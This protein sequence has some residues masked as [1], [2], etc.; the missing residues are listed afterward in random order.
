MHFL[1]EARA[2]A[3]LVSITAEGDLVT[4]AFVREYPEPQDA[5]KKYTITWFDMFRIADGKIVEHWGPA[6]K[7]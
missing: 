4:L 3:P 7:Q 2:K 1:I 6:V 5:S